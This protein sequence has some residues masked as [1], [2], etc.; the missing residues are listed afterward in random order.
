MPLVGDKVISQG[1]QQNRC[2]EERAHGLDGRGSDDFGLDCHSPARR[3]SLT[4]QS[5]D[6]RWRDENPDSS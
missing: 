6:A 5:R 4:E 2:G 1:K 3:G